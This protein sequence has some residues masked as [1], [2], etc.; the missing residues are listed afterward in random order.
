MK[1]CPSED[2]MRDTSVSIADDDQRTG[3]ALPEFLTVPEMAELL[4]LTTNTVYELFAQGELP[5]GRKLG[6]RAIRFHRDTVLQWFRSQGR[7]SPP[8]GRSG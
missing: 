7:G 6:R 3:T 4:R 8:S 5:G 2:T 1:N